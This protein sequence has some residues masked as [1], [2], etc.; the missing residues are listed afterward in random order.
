MVRPYGPN[1]DGCLKGTDTLLIL[2]SICIIIGIFNITTTVIAAATTT[3]TI[4]IT[5]NGGIWRRVG[6]AE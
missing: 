6:A 4:N 2:G 5:I 3:T 1:L